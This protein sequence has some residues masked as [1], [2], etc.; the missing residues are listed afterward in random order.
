M[1]TTPNLEDYQDHSTSAASQN[2][3]IGKKAKDRLKPLRGKIK[4]KPGAIKDIRVRKL[5]RKSKS[6]MFPNT[7]ERWNKARRPKITTTVKLESKH[8]AD[9]KPV[10]GC[11]PTRTPRDVMTH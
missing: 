5:K 8:K 7:S 1:L 10:H 9:P 4:D 3:Q 2:T 6:A 11:L